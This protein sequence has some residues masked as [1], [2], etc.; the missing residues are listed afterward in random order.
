MQSVKRHGLHVNQSADSQ[1]GQY[2]LFE[3]LRSRPPALSYGKRIGA[4][5]QIVACSYVALRNRPH[6]VG[7]GTR[8]AL[9]H[10]GKRHNFRDKARIKA[11]SKESAMLRHRPAAL[12]AVKVRPG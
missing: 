11:Q 8:P 4:E 12:R 9:Y 5:Y 7:A 2:G 1:P 10:A 6:S 3:V